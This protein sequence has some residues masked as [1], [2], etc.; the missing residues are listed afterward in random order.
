MKIYSESKKRRLKKYT[1]AI[2]G[3]ASFIF[4]YLAAF[5][6]SNMADNNVNVSAGIVQMFE[7]ISRLE[8]FYNPFNAYLIIDLIL[9]AGV[10]ALV[11]WLV[12]NDNER[13]MAFDKEAVAGTGGFMDE[14]DLLDYK[15][16]YDIKDE[17]KPILDNLPV[18]YD[19]EKDKDK[20]SDNI[21]LSQNFRRPVNSR[22]I[23][24]NNNVMVVGSAGTGKSRYFIKPNILQMNSSYIVT[25]P[26]GEVIAS[27]G[28]CLRD[29]GYKIKIF[30]TSD[31]MHS[32]CYNPLAYIRDEAGVDMV[33]ECLIEN[34]TGKG[35]KGDEFF[36]NA[37]KLLYGACIHYLIEFGKDD[38]QKNFTTVLNMINAS[39]VDEN[40]PSKP[41]PLDRLFDTLPK[42]SLA[43][44]QY[45]AFK[46][47]AGKT[48]KSIIISCVVR[49]RPF[50]TP[51]V[52]AL[53]SHD[54]LDLGSIGDEKTALFIITP[55]ADRTY[56]F[57]ASMLYSQLFETLYYKGEQQKA[58]GGSEQT[59]IPVRCLM[60]EFANIGTVPD[61][62]GKLA[63]M[64]KYNISAT[65][66]L[67]DIAQ[68]EAMYKDDWKTLV[69]NCSTSVFLGSKEPNTLKYYA[70]QL[71]K[72]TVQSK[73]RSM[74][75]NGKSTSASFQ[76]TGRE[77]M[78]A[79]ELGRL[80][81][82]ECI[83]YTYSMRPVRD[84]KYNYNEHPYFPLTSDADEKN[85]FL[86]KNIS[87][88]NNTN[89][90]SVESI[91]KADAECA[92]LREHRELE[93]RKEVANQ[94]KIVDAKDYQYEGSMID[95]VNEN[96]KLSPEEEESYYAANL[97]YLERK[98]EY[99]NSN[100]ANII[101]GKNII[102]RFLKP[103]VTELTAISN[104][105]RTIVFS[106]LSL[107]NSKEEYKLGIAYGITPDK[108]IDE[109]LRE[110]I[111]NS[112]YIEAYEEEENYMLLVIKKADFSVFQQEINNAL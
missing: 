3:I 58:N 5:V 27:T 20:Y 9:S 107:D 98:L 12:R 109:D 18:I 19:H 48:L 35:G 87:L 40:D 46:Q 86:Y 44:R 56:A 68:I 90:Y 76:S 67:Q 16:Q 101:I 83:V 95:F 6:T 111:I 11:Y 8:L 24:G 52:E 70:D 39:A 26:S 28:K 105:D 81:T 73:S 14:N 17:P 102:P 96:V 62:P 2:A 32:N 72:M 53:V 7:K 71:G 43:W 49:L 104:N 33:I 94:A 55:Q 88:Y 66:M 30:N 51:Q 110:A 97:H 89:K 75:K 59:K 106:N 80:P 60:D 69:G 29:H 61:F 34:T 64:R 84:K 54:N 82:D 112:R 15:E 13:H 50:M 23:P 36:V 100:K 4:L 1:I 45:K 103:L 47:A 38:S 79:E 25:D 41:S 91:M 93:A 37:E 42:N 21:I 78:T 74:Q 85:A 108:T 63:T 99:T 65:V 10:F 22:K 77:V 57:L 31:M 92:K